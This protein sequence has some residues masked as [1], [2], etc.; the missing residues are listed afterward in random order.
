LVIR[1]KTWLL[2]KFA[3]LVP[4]HRD[5]GLKKKNDNV[6]F[7]VPIVWRESKNT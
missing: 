1:T 4:K 2:T 7:G 5:R 3:Q 6:K